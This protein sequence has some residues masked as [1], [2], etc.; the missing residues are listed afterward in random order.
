M[1]VAV[2][3]GGCVFGRRPS[4]WSRRSWRA[5][6]GN[7]DVVLHWERAGMIWRGLERKAGKRMG[8]ACKHAI[9][10]MILSESV[11]RSVRHTA[12]ELSTRSRVCKTHSN[13]GCLASL[14]DIVAHHERLSGNAHKGG[15][16]SRQIGHCSLYF[17]Q[18]S[19]QGAMEDMPTRSHHVRPS[20]EYPRHGSIA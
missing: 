16:V 3:R 17:I 6:V 9:R 14:T 19:K 4:R 20:G 2:V 11:N 18:P 7:V 12:K 10:Q 1:V 8:Q 13:G 5:S 15:N